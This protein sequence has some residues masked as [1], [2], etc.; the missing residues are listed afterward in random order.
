M[1][2]QRTTKRVSTKISKLWRKGGYGDGGGETLNINQ[3]NEC[4]KFLNSHAMVKVT[5]FE[6]DNNKWASLIWNSW[7]G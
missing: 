7:K 3:N 5:D 4:G 1:Y 6:K 2:L